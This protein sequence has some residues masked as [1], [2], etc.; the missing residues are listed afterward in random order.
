MATLGGANALGLGNSIGSL[1]PGKRADFIAVDLAQI[2][3]PDGISCF[4]PVERVVFNCEPKNVR[5][6]AVEGKDID[7]EG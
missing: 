3:Q 5:F 6:V 1:V 2:D 4:D 7:I